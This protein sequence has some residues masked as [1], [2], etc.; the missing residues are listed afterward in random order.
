MKIIIVSTFLIVVR[1]QYI[2]TAHVKH[3]GHSLPSA[4]HRIDSFYYPYDGKGEAGK[5]SAKPKD[6]PPAVRPPAR[7]TQGLRLET[8]STSDH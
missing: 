8:M 4:G 5:G 2:N 1:I 3:L 7:G 6:R